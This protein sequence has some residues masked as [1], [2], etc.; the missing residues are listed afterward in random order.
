M[1]RSDGLERNDSAGDV[2]GAW[3]VA[4]G[5]ELVEGDDDQF[6]WEFDVGKLPDKSQE[7]LLLTILSAR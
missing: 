3:N 7:H 2:G 6:C 5:V 1:L 4:R